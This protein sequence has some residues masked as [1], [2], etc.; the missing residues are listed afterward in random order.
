MRQHESKEIMMI[1]SI[2]PVQEFIAQARRTRDLWFGSHLLSELSK[3]GAKEFIE[4][5]GRLVFPAMGS[6]TTTEQEQEI[7]APNKI[8]GLIDTN[9]PNKVAWQVRRAIQGK[10]KEYARAAEQQLGRIINIRTWDRQVSDLLEFQAA[11][12]ATQGLD[13][14]MALAKTEQ[15]LAARK[16]LR[17]FKQNDPGAMYGEKKSSLDGGRESVWINQDRDKERLSTLGIKKNESLD[18]ISVIKRLSLLLHPQQERFYSVCETAFLP[19]ENQIHDKANIRSAVDDYLRMVNT[20][21]GEQ[22]IK[23][24]RKSHA[25]SYDAR[26]FYE[27][28]IEDYLEECVKVGGEHK[29]SLQH[30]ISKELENMYSQLEKKSREDR[31]DFVRP[32]PYYAF[33]VADGDRMGQHLRGIKD[34]QS[35]IR[36]SKALSSFAVRAA[37]IMKDHQGQL[38]Y[39]GGD[40]VMAYLPVHTCLNAAHAL[41]Q[42]FIDVMGSVITAPT[43]SVGIVIT[44]MLEPLEEVRKMAHEAESRAKQTRDALEVHFYKRGGGSLMKVALPFRENPVEKIKI[45]SE[46]RSYFSS[47]FAYELRSMYQ[48]YKEMDTGS[49]WLRD[50]KLLGDLLWMEI[51]RL[52]FKKKP[53]GKDKDLLQQNWIPKLKELY[54]TDKEPLERLRTLAEQLILTI[55]LE[56]VGMVHEETAASKT[57]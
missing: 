41:R 20:L 39:S 40:D 2:G 29:E 52:A 30:S 26:L 38:V 36:F 44:H 27:R 11:W 42:A 46:H 3:A 18:A 50:R 16:T 45:L 10:W 7:S 17:D 14:D 35:H 21:L 24:P 15:L 57:P 54:D 23:P 34:E 31:L 48:S 22:K 49:S 47:Q 8:L 33:L 56:K 32:T 28:R 53:E 5:G 1:F 13:Y 4:Q 25:D 55:H 6:E 51:E 12:T 19:F 43:L 9:E 37:Q